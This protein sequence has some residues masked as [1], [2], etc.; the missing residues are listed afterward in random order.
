MTKVKTE[1]TPETKPPEPITDLI[2]I[3]N[4]QEFKWN[5]AEIKQSIESDIAKYVGLV[6][7]DE[8]LKDMEI[9]QKKIASIRTKVDGFRKAIKKKLEEPYKL[10]EGEIKE[11]LQLI[12]KA[13]TP[14]KDQ[15]SKYEQE[16][17]AAKEVELNKFAMAT[18]LSMGIRNSYYNFIVQST[19]TNRT[20]KDPVVRKEIVGMIESMLDAQRRDDELAEMEEQRIGLI[21][22]Q[23]KAHSALLKTPVVPADVNHLLVGVKL[24]DIPGIVLAECQKRAEMEARAAA[25]IEAELLA[26]MAAEMVVEPPYI[27]DVNPCTEKGIY[28]MPGAT[29]EYP[30]GSELL[31]DLGFDGHYQQSTPVSTEILNPASFTLPPMPPRAMPPLPLYLYKCVIE[32]P[33]ITIQEAIAI[34]EFLSSRAIS[35]NIISQEQLRSEF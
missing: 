28:I 32:Y 27:P 20:A 15:T 33:N 3:K 31:D 18:A 14:L 11:L 8:N 17:I 1:S 10:F 12:E 26:R 35:Y 21:E 23:C 22:G 16:R 6:V 30:G 5:F 24:S 7:N 34:K 2:I 25:E 4:V 29:P 19:W 13:E 9:A